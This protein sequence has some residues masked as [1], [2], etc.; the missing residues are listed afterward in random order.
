MNYIRE[1][2]TYLRHYKDLNDSLKNIDRE[3]NRLKLEGRPDDIKAIIYDD[4]PKAETMQDD[5]INV[6]YKLQCFMDMRQ[7]TANKLNS[8]DEILDELEENYPGYGVILK[9]WYVEKMSKERIAKQI[10]YSSKQS[11][12]THKNKAIRKFAI[13]LF[14]IGA[15]KVI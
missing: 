1:A 4:M 7:T 13:R 8:I 15:L 14:G 6:F 3:I 10:G 5:V 9:L 12:Y 11:I 2:E